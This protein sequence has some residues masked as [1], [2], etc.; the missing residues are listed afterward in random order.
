MF[1]DHFPLRA[2]KDTELWLFLDTQVNAPINQEPLSYFVGW[3]G[4]L[5]AHAVL[6]P[7]GHKGVPTLPNLNF[8]RHRIRNCGSTEFLQ[9][10]DFVLNMRKQL[11]NAGGFSVEV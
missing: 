6:N 7:R 3:A 4:I 5:S 10:L 11:I 8:S 1:H 2:K 9:Q